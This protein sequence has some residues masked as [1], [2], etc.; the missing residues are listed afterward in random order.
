VK[1]VF[2]GKY[3][4]TYLTDTLLRLEELVGEPVRY[5]LVEESFTRRDVAADRAVVN[6]SQVVILKQG[7]FFKQSNRIL[8]EN[9]EA[10]HVFLSFWGDKRLFRVL[11]RA[12]WC[13]QQVAV[14]FE[15]YASVPVGYWRDE[16]Q[17]HS[18]LKV[19]GRRFAY[20]GLWPLTRLFSRGKLP[21]VLAVSPLAEQQLR[22][23]GFR[24]EVIYPF[25]YFV[26]RKSVEPAAVDGAKALRVVFSG[27]FIKRKGADILIA[28]IRRV[29]GTKIN[30]LLDLYGPGQVQRFVTGDVPGVCYRGTY[31]QADAQQ[32]IS[33]YDLLV[34]P[35]RHE[36]WGL[37]VNE[38]LMQGV[39]V[40]ASDR[41]G[42]G[43]L[44]D[45][46]GAG[47]IFRSGDIAGLSTLLTELASNRARLNEMVVAC[48]RVRERITPALGADYLK[49]VIDHHFG[50]TGDRPKPGW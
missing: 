15:P 42:A 21:C 16:G 38:A 4:D 46:S 29:N 8:Q 10:M 37:V 36:G 44:L 45:H 30:V 34:V 48:T 35:S 43:C 1:I 11:L 26:E 6:S 24:D 2:W 9:R 5:A 18:Q 19:W 33:G 49:Q 7:R 28:A 32:V 39:P 41:V 14:I 25:G 23:I 22:C 3:I 50:G 47:I 31:P 27:S 17:L 12:L 20:R 40:L 13:R